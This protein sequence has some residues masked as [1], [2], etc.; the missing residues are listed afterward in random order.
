MTAPLRDTMRRFFA[1]G[2]LDRL[3]GRRDRRQRTWSGESDA[4]RS[5]ATTGGI[6]SPFAA[7]ASDATDH[8]QTGHHHS[9]HHHSG[10][11]HTSASD[12]NPGFFGGG[13]GFDGGE[14]WSGNDSSSGDSG[15]SD[16][17]G[18]GDAGGGSDSGGGGGDA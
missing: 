10:H 12:H 5:E 2:F 8:P 15:G 13:G 1:M 7:A 18:G 17:G 11:H 14:N 16:S 9:G 6:G 4:Y 3:F